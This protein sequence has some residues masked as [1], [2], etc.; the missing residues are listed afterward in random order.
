MRPKTRLENRIGI[1]YDD[2]RFPKDFVRQ[3]MPR[4][5]VNI[6][7]EE[8][9]RFCRRY[10]VRKFMLFGSILRDDFRPDSDVDVLVEF[11]PAHTPGLL[12]FSMQ[13]ELSDL[14]G[15]RVDLNTPRCLSRY[16]RDDVLREAEV[17]YAAP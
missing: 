16:F 7:P 13:E 5:N 10:H 8:I 14:L 3:T 9:A 4:H 17:L 1:G 12:F 2:R 15:K 6:S 11:E